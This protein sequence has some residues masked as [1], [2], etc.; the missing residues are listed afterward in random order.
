MPASGL[1]CKLP[2]VARDAPRAR[3]CSRSRGLEPFTDQLDGF[4]QRGWA[5]AEGAFDQARL[6]KD[7]ARQ[8]EDR[9]LTLAERTHHLK[10]LT[11]GATG[12]WFACSSSVVLPRNLGLSLFVSCS[13]VPQNLTSGRRSKQLAPKSLI[14]EATAR[15][16]GPILKAASCSQGLPRPI[17]PRSDEVLAFVDAM[18]TFRIALA[19]CG[20][21]IR[22]PPN[23]AFG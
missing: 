18:M 9:R 13:D 4:G 8:V 15:R 5:E 11:W 2:A 21:S 23:L 3:S 16:M 7:V 12:Q 19:L 14:L 6:A 17:H 1:C 10:A 22:R 20:P